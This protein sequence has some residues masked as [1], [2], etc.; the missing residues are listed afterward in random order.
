MI[1]G[2]AAEGKSLLI[3]S[4]ILTELAEISTKVAMIEQG[5]YWPTDRWMKSWSGP[6]L[7]MPSPRTGHGDRRTGMLNGVEQYLAGIA[8]GHLNIRMRGKGFEF[9]MADNPARHHELL[10]AMIEKG[11]PVHRFAARRRS[12]EEAFLHVTRGRVQ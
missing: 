11:F 3:S 4:H 5:Q 10:A 1:N 6:E 12:L 9:S 8:T 2:L 7:S